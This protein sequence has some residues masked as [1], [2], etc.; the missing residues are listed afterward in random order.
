MNSE[1]NFRKLHGIILVPKKKGQIRET[2]SKFWKFLGI[3]SPLS[4]PLRISGNC[5][6]MVRRF[7]KFNNS[8]IFRK[9]VSPRKFRFICP[10]FESY[11]IFGPKKQSVLM[12]EFAEAAVTLASF[13]HLPFTLNSYKRGRS[14][15]IA[16][17]SL[18]RDGLNAQRESSVY[19]RDWRRYLFR[20]ISK[21]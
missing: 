4:F 1:L 15:R 10:R 19:W 14:D 18:T 3:S 9:P 20:K 6:R 17:V 7:R 12:F 11:G 8:R 21:N 16:D 5:V 2:Y 13:L